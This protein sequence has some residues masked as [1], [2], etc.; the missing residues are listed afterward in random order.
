LKSSCRWTRAQGELSISILS[1]AL[2]GDWQTGSVE[3]RH[4]RASPQTGYGSARPPWCED[5]VVIVEVVAE[6]VDEVWWHE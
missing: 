6:D 4:L 2:S 3:R 5:R 1:K